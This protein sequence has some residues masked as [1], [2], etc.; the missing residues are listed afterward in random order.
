MTCSIVRLFWA[1]VYPPHSKK[2]PGKVNS[3]AFIDRGEPLQRISVER[4]RLTTLD[5]C[6][7]NGLPGQG[8]ASITV[9]AV[10]ALG[11]D[12]RHTPDDGPTVAHCDIVPPEGEA[13]SMFHY[14]GL[15]SACEV[16]VPPKPRN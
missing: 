5:E 12:V 6:L 3:T 7:R 4:A 15:A 1:N 14:R 16:A 13:I 11:L 10:R 8:V 2:H 9:R